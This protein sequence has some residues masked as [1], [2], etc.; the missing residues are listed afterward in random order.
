MAKLLAQFF[1]LIFGHRYQVAQEFNSYSRRV[2]C[3]HC[4]GDWGMNDEMSAFIPWDE[5]LT[6]LYQSQGHVVHN[7]WPSRLDGDNDDAR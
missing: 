1:C 6:S 2:V 7:P 3:P 5:E 4:G